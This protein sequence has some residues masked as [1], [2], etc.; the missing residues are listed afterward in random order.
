[1]SEE[2][3][4]E[5]KRVV[6]EIQKERDLVRVEVKILEARNRS[7]EESLRELT[8]QN[9]MQNPDQKAAEPVNCDTLDKDALITQLKHAIDQRENE[10]GDLT[11]KT[12]NLD[13][14]NSLTQKLY[15]QMKQ[16]LTTASDKI[17]LLNQQLAQ[18]A[19]ANDIREKESRAA[20][21]QLE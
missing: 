8:D 17:K 14:A 4:V 13:K 2:L 7:L 10:I 16:E 12:A 9:K 5:R 18:Q 20:F 6:S 15:K 3:A 19:T 11:Q 1:M 21:Q